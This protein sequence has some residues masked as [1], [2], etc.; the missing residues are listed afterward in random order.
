[1]CNVSTH[2]YAPCNG[3]QMSTILRLCPGNET[4]VSVCLF[5]TKR[6]F[7]SNMTIIASVGVVAVIDVV[8]SQAF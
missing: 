7:C 8:R 1:M 6:M 2:L 3:S 4:H 5:H